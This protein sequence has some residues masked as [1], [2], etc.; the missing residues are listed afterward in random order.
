MVDIHNT[1]INTAMMRWGT[2]E[3]KNKY[4]PLFAAS[5]LG[6]FALSEPN[7]GSDA[8]AL[9]TTATADGD[10]YILNGNKCWISNAAEA[11]VFFVMAN[12]DPAA[13]Y[14]GITCFIV[15]AGTPGLE[16][17]KKEDKLGIRASSTCELIL[18]EVRVPASSI[19]GNKGEGYKSQS[20]HSTR[21]VSGLAHKWWALHK[22][23]TTMPSNIYT[24][25]NNLA[26]QWLT[27]R[28][29][30]SSTQTR[31]HRSKW[32]VFW[33]ITALV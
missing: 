17:G 10:D 16:V 12:V 29:C 2:E 4:L 27:F 13:G 21:D 26:A 1:L 9:K 15:D 6:S 32:R 28:G 14:K 31:R 23:P 8:F 20:S 19:L 25:E 18:Q 11:G 33:Y 22:V 3:Q 24:R 5:H 30:N 7:A